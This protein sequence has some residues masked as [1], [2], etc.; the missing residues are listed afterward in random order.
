[1]IVDKFTGR[2]K[3]FGFVEMSTDS[4]A[5]NAIRGAERNSMAERSMSVK[6][7]RGKTKRASARK[8]EAAAA[9]IN[10]GAATEDG[11]KRFRVVQS[12][13]VQGSRSES[14]TLNA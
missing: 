1:V 8:A 10:D 2:S 6:P 7:N 11:G 4:E 5:E 3:G 13:N 9:V 12:S 14:G